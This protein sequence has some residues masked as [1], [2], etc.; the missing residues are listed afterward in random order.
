MTNVFIMQCGKQFQ[1]TE[2]YY[3]SNNQS[4]LIF[5]SNNKAAY[6]LKINKR[7]QYFQG[8]F[9]QSVP[10]LDSILFHMEIFQ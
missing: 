10:F 8:H 2:K 5:Q 4:K 1:F 9:N 6:C 7:C 3:Q